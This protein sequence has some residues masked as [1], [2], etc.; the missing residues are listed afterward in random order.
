MSFTAA[1]R[2]LN[3]L[4][5]FVRVA[6]RRSFTLAA[7]ELR[8]RPSVVSKRMK[9]LEDA[10]GFRLLNRSTHGLALTDAGEGLFAHCLQIMAELDDYVVE[11]RNLESGPFG[12]LRVQVTNDYA[13]WVLAPL[14]A[15]FVDQHPRIR[16]QLAVVPDNFASA[17][18]GVD[19]IVSSR[20]PAVPGVVGHDLGA[21][22]H[23]V[24]ASPQYF[25]KFGRPK[26]PQDLREHNCLIDPFAAAKAWPFRNASRPLLVEAKGSLSS[27][28]HA[29]LVELAL[30]HCGITR[31][32]LHAVKGEIA[33]RRLEV[34]FKASS[35]SP[36]RMWAYVAKSK[37]LPAK[38]ANFI[39]FLK[40]KVGRA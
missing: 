23:V 14:S 33:A 37:R 10:L 39:D 31:V 22:R 8:T 36:E 12:T 32:P 19:V 11:R 4:N 26:T 29:V 13:R 20:K 21:I 3:K 34:I 5:T 6:Q 15:K 24:C 28:S 1:L 7:A 18:D 25:G 30:Q 35:L 2:D 27:N 16:L 17:E 40:A 9:E 38:T